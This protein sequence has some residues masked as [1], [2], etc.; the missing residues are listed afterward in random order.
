MRYCN[1]YYKLQ[2]INRIAKHITPLVLYLY[3]NIYT[4]P[5]KAGLLTTRLWRFF[6]QQ[7][8]FEIVNTSIFEIDS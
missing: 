4:Q 1:I 7:Y 6:L 3:F 2:V 8:K 5:Y